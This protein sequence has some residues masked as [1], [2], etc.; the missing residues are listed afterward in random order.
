MEH[1]QIE[2]LRIPASRVALG[3]WAI[4]GW[5]W[6]GT[7]EKDAVETIHA[8]LDQG[9]NVID[10]TPVYGFGRPKRLLAKR[11]AETGA[12]TRLSPPRLASNG[13]MGTFSGTPPRRGSAP[14]WK[15]R[16]AG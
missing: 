8:A 3:T 1:I 11:L 10:T 6:G 13:A 16:F 7:G 4:G 2:G 12:A 14:S 5:M 15:T 9:I